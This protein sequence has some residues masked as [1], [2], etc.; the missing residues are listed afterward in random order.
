MTNDLNSL[1]TFAERAAA[2]PRQGSYPPI[3][4]PS[5]SIEKAR[6]NAQRIVATNEAQIT[7]DRNAALIRFVFTT[8]IPIITVIA[9]FAIAVTQGMSH[10]ATP[11]IPNPFEALTTALSA[12]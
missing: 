2:K 9:F 5:V 8:I 12:K 7:A 3:A 11:A 1:P 4:H 10:V 6:A